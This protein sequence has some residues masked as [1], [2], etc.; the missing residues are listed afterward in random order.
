[1][2]AGR[3][4]A[5]RRVRETFEIAVRVARRLGLQGGVAGEDPSYRMSHAHRR[6]SVP[7]AVSVDRPEKIAGWAGPI[8]SNAR[9]NPGLAAPPDLGEFHRAP[10]L[11]LLAQ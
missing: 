3:K 5:H 7:S 1:M 10:L 6:L 4:P 9:G 11:R 8:A 2:A